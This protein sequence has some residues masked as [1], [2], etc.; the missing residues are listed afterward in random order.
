MKTRIDDE[1]FGFLSGAKQRKR[2]RSS[3]L[4]N[5]YSWCRT[6]IFLST[7]SF[8]SLLL[9]NF[10]VFQKIKE[11]FRV[12]EFDQANQP[13]FNVE[14]EC[15]SEVSMPEALDLPQFT[16]FPVDEDNVF[17]A[18]VINKAFTNES[19]C[20]IFSMSSFSNKSPYRKHFNFPKYENTYTFDFLITGVGRSGTT[21]MY[22][23]FKQL[24]VP[25]SHDHI[26]PVPYKS[27]GSASWQNAFNDKKCGREPGN[28]AALGASSV[29]YNHVFHLIRNP[30]KQINSRANAGEFSFRNFVT[31]PCSV[32]YFDGYDM[33]GIPFS[34]RLTQ[35]RE[36]MLA[37]G[38]SLFEIS[39]LLA[40]RHWV[41]YNTFVASYA[42][43][44][45]KIENMDSD[46]HKEKLL[47][48]ILD[49]SETKHYV[50]S[51]NWKKLR[52]NEV[53]STKNSGHT[54]KKKGFELSWSILHEL[55]EQFTAMAQIV[56][57]RFGYDIPI[58]ER[59]K[60]LQEDTDVQ[61]YFDVR[62]QWA[63][64]LIN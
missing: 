24:R 49:E 50:S 64:E 38:L 48:L 20:K 2:R 25:V 33:E 29:R 59:S 51:R 9:I 34:K 19:F 18:A 36:A 30:L 55:D 11:F 54:V 56:A 53:S 41:L 4:F 39:L 22:A 13:L 47:K 52:T 8:L 31:I 5:S 17:R 7:L 28:F 43:F 37:E 6:L 42:E 12:L 16:P 63:C 15:L 45:F 60:M 10:Q 32:D 3:R 62:E 61:C 44:T 40:L 23:E 58:E 57:S 1:A 14:V 35:Y 46:D 26:A 27:I 21:F